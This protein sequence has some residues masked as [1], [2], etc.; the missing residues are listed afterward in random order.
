MQL[1]LYVNCTTKSMHSTREMGEQPVRL[2][3]QDK[4]HSH[5]RSIDKKPRGDANNNDGQNHHNGATMNDV[6][7]RTKM[8]TA[9]PSIP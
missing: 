3:T 5:D 9:S 7:A 4:T 2:Y 8:R 6:S 1:F